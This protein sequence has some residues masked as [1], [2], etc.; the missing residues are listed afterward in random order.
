MYSKCTS[1]VI[2]QPTQVT[3]NITSTGSVTC[4]GGNN[5]F[6][7]VTAGGGTG[8][9]TLYIGRQAEAHAVNGKYINRRCLCSNSSG[10][11]LMYSD[12]DSNHY[13]NQHH[14]ATTLTTTNVLCNAACDGTANI[15][16]T[17]G[18]VA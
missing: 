13:Y 7:V 3:A 8:A 6:A 10:S 9:H 1:I 5:G 4:N 18:A 15:A 2:T 16:Y 12:S 14:L 11:K 17:G